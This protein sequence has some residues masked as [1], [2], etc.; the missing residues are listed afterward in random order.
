MA[1]NGL[2]RGQQAP[3]VIDKE[4]SDGLLPEIKRI[5]G[6]HLLMAA[7]RVEDVE[8]A[9]DLMAITLTLPE[10]LRVACR[11]RRGDQLRRDTSWGEEFTLRSGRPNGVKTELA[12]ILEG[13]GSHLFYAFADGEIL[14]WL[15]AD[16][17][18]FRLWFYR[19]LATHGGAMPGK[20]IANRDHSSTFLAIPIEDL[21]PEFVLARALPP[22]ELR[23]RGG[24]VGVNAIDLTG[25]EETA[26]TVDR[27]PG[28][29]DR[30]RRRLDAEV[31]GY[32]M[33]RLV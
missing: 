6:E 11:I 32:R 7:P 9:T 31:L 19:H 27:P 5:L 1:T 13:W 3:W 26:P 21:P 20:E 23:W 8:R 30:G 16:L 12:K 18:V 22:E 24:Y 33:E 25:A 14:S 2:A 4:W 10:G 29:A 15:L 28:V 17:K